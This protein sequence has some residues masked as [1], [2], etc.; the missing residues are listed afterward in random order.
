MIFDLKSIPRGRGRGKTGELT[1]FPRRHR[2]VVES[3]CAQPCG[4]PGCI[5]TWPNQSEDIDLIWLADV[6]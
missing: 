4:F 6:V 2:M 1:G 3:I 5:E